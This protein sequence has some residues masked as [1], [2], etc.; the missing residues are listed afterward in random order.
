MSLLESLR[1][2]LI[3]SVQAWRG[4]ALDDPY[5]IAAM[6]RAAQAG[7][8]VAVRIAG[9]DHLRAVR[10]RVALPIVGLDQARVRRI[11]DRTLRRRSRKCARSSPRRGD[12]RV[13]RDRVARVRTA[14]SS[15]ISIAAI[16]AQRPS[17]ARRLLD[18]RRRDRRGRR[19]CRHRRNDALRL[20]RRN[21]RAKRCRRSISFASSRGCGASPSA[22]A[23]SALRRMCAPRSMPEPMRSCVGSAITNVDWLV[24]EFAGAADRV[25]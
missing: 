5:V 16:H 1:G 9:I 14:P 15:A 10:A 24:R 8:A 17:S 19:R 22:R 2:G 23:A 13:R 21:R 11:R 12:R 4:S 7:G 6:A 25:S 18:R 20:H 3:V